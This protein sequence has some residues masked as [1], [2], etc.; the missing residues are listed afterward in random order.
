MQS[1]S[2]RATVTGE[3]VN[4]E[5]FFKAA[6]SAIRADSTISGTA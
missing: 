5:T 1:V 6:Y 2:A 4:S 3:L